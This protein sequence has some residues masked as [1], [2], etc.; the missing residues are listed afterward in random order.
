MSIHLKITFLIQNFNRC[1][2]PVT[3]NSDSTTTKQWRWII[4]CRIGIRGSDK[5][6]S[7][8]WIRICGS[9]RQEL[10]S[11]IKKFVE[12]TNWKGKQELWRKTCGQFR[13]SSLK[14]DWR[15]F[16]LHYFERFTRVTC[17]LSQLRYLTFQLNDLTSC[18]W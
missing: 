5:Q 8:V 17:I 13:Y 7:D 14:F 15:K 2:P 1:K 12:S 4:L 3:F 11:T 16:I 9:V 18:F 10:A 6:D